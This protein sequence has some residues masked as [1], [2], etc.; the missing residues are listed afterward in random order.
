MRAMTGRLC[1]VLALRT[2]NRGDERCAMG[3]GVDDDVAE[4]LVAGG[5]KT[6]VGG[7][8]QGRAV[9]A[10]AEEAYAALEA[11]VCGQAFEPAF[12]RAVA[13]D[14]QHGAVDVGHRPDG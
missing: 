4:R 11:K 3:P 1:P 12:L 8:Q 14:P 6:D 2:I 5:H 10:P 13:R 7:L 9:V